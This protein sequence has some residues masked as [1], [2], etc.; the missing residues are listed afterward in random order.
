MGILRGFLRK[1]H[2]AA[3]R[4]QS[5]PAGSFVGQEIHGFI[6]KRVEDIP[7]LFIKS[8]VLSHIKT[9]ADYIHLARDD[10]NNVF[11][12]GFRTIP[13]DST[14]VPHILE[15]TVLCGSQ[16]YPVRDPFFKMLNRSLSTFMNAMT[17][18]D[19]TMYP[20]S[21]QNDKDFRNLMSVYLD[22]VFNPKLEKLDFLQ[23][24][25]RLEPEN[26]EDPN[27]K[28][29]I[30]GVVFNEMKGVYADPQSNLSQKIMNTLLPSHTYATVYGGDP[31]KIPSL[32]WEQLKNFH[33]QF[34]HPSN[35]KFISYGNIPFE[36]HLKFLDEEYLS[37]YDKI[38]RAAVV[39]L[40]PKW[41]TSRRIEVESRNDPMAPEK[42]KQTTV[43][44]SFSLNDASDPLEST[45]LQ[46]ISQLLIDGPN[47][48]FYKS[49]LE[50]NIG[51]GYT[52]VTGYDAHSRNAMFTIGL[53]GVKTEDS[54]KV[55]EVIR[56]TFEDA[57]K[58]G[59]PTERIEA[60]LHK[61]ELSIKHQR[62]NFGLGLAMGLTPPWNHEGDPL[63]FLK[64]NER[65]SCFRN[66]IKENPNFLQEKIRQ[67]FIDNTH[68]LISVMSP[69]VD[70]EEKQLS[71]EQSLLKSKIDS[72]T[73]DDKEIML[74]EALELN[75]KQKHIEDISVLP[76]LLIEDIKPM[77]EKTT[78]DHISIGD[79]NVQVCL[80]PTNGITYFRAI[81][82]A[83]N[84]PDHLR[85]YVPLFCSLATEMGVKGLDYRQFDQEVQ[86]RTGGFGVGQHI[87][88]EVSSVM[89]YEDGIMIGSHCLDSNIEHMFKLWSKIFLDL[90]LSD[91]GRLETLVRGMVGDY[92]N[93]LVRMGHAYAMGGAS[94]CLTPVLNIRESTEGLTFIRELRTLTESGKF[95]QILENVQKVAKIILSDSQTRCSLNCIPT[96]RDLA[97]KSLE[98]F[99]TSINLE[100]SD[101]S[102]FVVDRS[103]FKP[104]S[105]WTYNILP[106]PVN[107]VSKAVPTVPFSSSDFAPLRI[108]CRLLSA[109]YL[110][111][112]VREK[113]GAYGS[114]AVVGSHG[115]LQFY[116]YRDPKGL[117][118]LEVFNKSLDW[119]IKAN[120]D[121]QM[122][123]EAKLSVFQ[124][125]DAPV[126]PGSR[127]SRFFVHGI[128]DELYEKH[129]TELKQTRRDDVLRVA[130]KY[131]NTGLCGVSVLGPQTDKV[132]SDNRWK[133]F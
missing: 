101:S 56:T 28:W 89:K 119:L 24:G 114:G 53:Q 12:I 40:E 66:Q 42:D 10:S 94:S 60:V 70:Y 45:I 9:G 21:T 46:I 84:V 118:T 93:S 27:S 86:L 20:F 79:T 55:I 129:R 3:L 76:T 17:G 85:M 29:I 68:Q 51:I 133:I 34:Y 23:E 99:L 90:T 115:A 88:E 120:I 131:L 71:S 106:V 124:K 35:A 18:P 13:T 92:I 91:V 59:F 63:E 132:T 61:I 96:S 43:A 107:F 98:N 109:K 11:S 74:Q 2:F 128:S 111:T 4:F 108:L 49:L 44:V 31:L 5:R 14:G 32:T 104:A 80:Q 75:K 37:K 102:R 121:D 8:T 30:K 127:G 130:E 97:V 113:G 6:V 116:S 81:L 33:R 87:S 50:P 7:E 19:F 36:N 126:P 26:L 16:K 54:E 112:E 52:P 64:V 57:A 47:S 83:K 125:V 62:S 41:T 38:D 39:P 73:K 67:Y 25:W 1:G 15:H 58:N 110:H 122:L 78:L 77:L 123:L 100:K 48:P 82:S 72:L 117:E 105:Q 69:V 65:L 103:T 95:E 22:A